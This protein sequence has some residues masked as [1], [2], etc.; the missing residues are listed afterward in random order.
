MDLP[1]IIR[2][3]VKASITS[4]MQGV[5]A[6]T[7]AAVEA[8]SA[9]DD[10]GCGLSLIMRSHLRHICG[11]ACDDNVPSIWMEMALARTKAKVLALLLQFFLTGMNACQPTFHGHDDLLH[12]ALPLFN[13]FT[14][15]A[16]TNHG[17]HPACPSGGISP[18][19]SLQGMVDRGGASH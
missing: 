15:G 18:W 17:N 10:C 11:V 4:A 1:A 12:I 6:V 8:L 19:T 9:A 13:F 7:T 16:F 14:R 3:A 5:A 2:S